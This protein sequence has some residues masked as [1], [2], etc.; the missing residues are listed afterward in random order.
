MYSHRFPAAGRYGPPLLGTPHDVAALARL[1]PEVLVPP[2]EGAETA[3]AMIQACACTMSGFF[4]LGMVASSS[5]SL[6]KTG[7]SVWSYRVA[8]SPRT[9]SAVRW[10]CSHEDG[11][12][13]SGLHWHGQC[14]PLPAWLVLRCTTPMRSA[15]ASTHP[16]R[17]QTV[18]RSGDGSDAHLFNSS[19]SPR[20]VIRPDSSRCTR[21]GTARSAASGS[22][23][24]WIA[25]IRS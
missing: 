14:P 12:L 15:R 10:T 18:R 6:T 8:R 23:T 1:F 13:E 11:R 19:T 7:V 3:Y 22:T 5:R 21:T 24:A 4:S 9:C 2:P 25:A 20:K 16:M 17:A